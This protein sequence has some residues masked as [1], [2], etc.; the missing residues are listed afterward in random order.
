MST[1][2]WLCTGMHETYQTILSVVRHICF[3]TGSAILGFVTGGTYGGEDTGI[4]NRL[5]IYSI[6]INF[7]ANMVC[8]TKVSHS[9]ATGS[10]L[11]MDTHA[12]VSCAGIDAYILEKLDGRLCEVRGFHDSYNS[13]TN[14]EYVNVA[15]KYLDK[16]GQEY[17]LEVNQALNFT[18]SMTNSI[19]CTNQARHNGV[20]INDI[21]RVIDKQSP[22]C[23][24]FPSED[25]HLPLI[26]KGPV[27]VIPVTKPT[28]IEVQTLPRLQL[29]SSDTLW[30]P[31]ELFGNYTEES[32]NAWYDND[33]VY[34][35]ISGMEIL[36]N[37]ATRDKMISSIIGSP[38]SNKC[39]ARYL[40]KL[41][42]I[43]LKAA[44]RTID[45]TTQTSRRT[46]NE[47]GL[48][49]RVRTKVHQ[50]RYRQLDGHLGRFSSDT[51][52]SSCKSLRGNQC[53][54]LFTNKA[55]YTKSYC[56]ESKSDAHFA[57]NR[58]VHE[59]GV[60]TELHT[61]GS[62][63]QALGRWRKICQKHAIYRTWTEPH[64]P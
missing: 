55:A 16:T 42:G 52:F 4:F 56:M 5:E 20:I 41:W 54:Q 39:D 21:P 30:N 49:K 2:T 59:V 36:E 64:S 23:V 50:R 29:T 27:P 47:L 12:D 18:N 48:S 40:A 44:Q 13:L 51:F 57:L 7:P 31:N 22:Q 61:D 11:G 34:Q 17:L 46:S 26:M 24:S 58:F 1:G 9:R 6:S 25:I 32:G 63:E 3:T 53:F 38:R 35:M 62:K 28:D 14:V 10:V 37:V 45:S 43:G 33:P 60:P 15:Y 19:I 8:K